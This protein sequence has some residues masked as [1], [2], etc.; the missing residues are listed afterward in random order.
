MDTSNLLKTNQFK[1]RRCFIIGGGPS[2]QGLDFSLI[3]NDVTIGINKAF[4]YY[5]KCTINY[6]MDMSWYTFLTTPTKDPDQLRAQEAWKA[7]K[8]YKTWVSLSAFKTTPPKGIQVIKKIKEQNLSLNL[9]HGIFG[10]NNSGWGA[11]NIALALGCNPVYLLGYDMKMSNNKTHWHEGYAK[12]RPQGLDRRLE[13]FGN[14]I[15]KF[16]DVI[17]EMG[18]QVINLN[19]DSGLTCFPKMEFNKLFERVGNVDSR[20]FGQETIGEDNSKQLSN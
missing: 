8:G 1:G 3:E 14:M 4:M 12:T 15:A 10:G 5:P 18:F 19:P 20:L 11:I 2:V 16:A 6:A 13:K 9:E 17:S 7:Y